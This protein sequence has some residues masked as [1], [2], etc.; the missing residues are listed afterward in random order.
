MATT[1]TMQTQTEIGMCDIA[2]YASTRRAMSIFYQYAASC[3][4]I[5]FDK[6]VVFQ[7][8]CPWARHFYCV[9]PYKNVK[10][11]QRRR[12]K[13]NEEFSMFYGLR[14]DAILWIS[15]YIILFPNGEFYFRVEAPTTATTAPVAVAM[16][17]TCTQ[18]FVHSHPP[19]D[20]S[21]SSVV[22]T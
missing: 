8:I 3:L 19:T 15:I 14:S 16:P 17:S 1:H 18:N 20:Y 21:C 13:A 10:T 2:F 7:K 6:N 5:T 11:G 9:H 22:C 12:K 4:P